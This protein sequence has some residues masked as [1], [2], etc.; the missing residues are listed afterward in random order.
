MANNSKRVGPKMG[1]LEIATLLVDVSV[2]IA[3][4]VVALIG[5]L[6]APQNNILLGVGGFM[7]L[8]AF[9]A[10]FA[11]C[12]DMLRYKNTHC[13]V[14]GHL[15][16]VLSVDDEGVTIT[17]KSSS[18]FASSDRKQTVSFDCQCPN[19]GHQHHFSHTFATGHSD[20]NGHFTSKDI[21]TEIK[22]FWKYK[23]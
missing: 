23:K 22:K 8:V 16:D 18:T 11:A 2:L 12:K 21:N 10:I 7:V 14:C 4:V 17:D 5:Y 1:G 6:R 13:S 20:S 3:G 15:Y 19:C 9:M